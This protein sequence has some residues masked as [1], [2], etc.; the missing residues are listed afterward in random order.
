MIMDD[1]KEVL[2]KVKIE[3]YIAQHLSRS[4]KKLGTWLDMGKCPF[5]GGH[6]CFRIQP[7]QQFFNCFQCEA[8]GDVITFVRLYNKLNTNFDALKIVAKEIGYNLNNSKEFHKKS[9]NDAM[10]EKI[11]S[12]AAYYYHQNLFKDNK[13]L[14][15][16]KEKRCHTE[17]I[18]KKFIIGYTGNDPDGLSKY[19]LQQGFEHQQILMTGLAKQDNTTLKDFFC[20]HL[21]IYPW[22]YYSFVGH[23]SMK[24]PQKKL[25]Y[26]LPHKFKH[27]NLLFY[28]QADIFRDKIILVEGENDLLTVYR[29]IKNSEQLK[30]FGVIGIHGQI[31]KEQLNYLRGTRQEKEIYCCF[32]NDVESKTGEKYTHKV[33]NAICDIAE[34][35]VLSFEDKYKDIDEYLRGDDFPGM[36]LKALIDDSID[37]IE[38]KITRLPDC[39]KALKARKIIEPILEIIAKIKDDR[40]DTYIEL[41]TD[42]Y[43]CLKKQ[44][45]IKQLK[46]KGA[47]IGTNVI[48]HFEIYDSTSQVYV[49]ENSYY[50][51]IKDG[52]PMVSNFIFRLIN[53]Y[54]YEDLQMNSK[55]LKYECVMVNY[56]DIKSEPIVFDPE[57]R[58]NVNKFMAKAASLGEY[59]FW[60]SI[61]NLL[62]VWSFVEHHAEDIKTTFL[63]QKYGY[64]QSADLWLFNDCA[65]KDG[66]IY[67]KKKDV[68]FVNDKGYKSDGVV[69]YGMGK[70]E[71]NVG[72]ATD[73][74]INDTVKNYWQICDG[75]DEET[76]EQWSSFKGL[77]MFGLNAAFVY[78]EEI[79]KKYGFFPFLLVFSGDESTG[80]TE[81]MKILFSFWGFNRSEG[82]MYGPTTP[83]GLSQLFS[84]LCS[85]PIWLD[86]FRINTNPKHVSVMEIIRNSYNR[87][88]VSKG[89]VRNRV[90][91]PIN[92]GI[93]I[94]GQDTPNDSAT[95][96]RFIT[97]R[98][99]KV[100]DA[101]RKV[102]KWFKN[103][104]QKLPGIILRFIKEKSKQS[105][106]D[107]LDNIDAIEDI[108]F[109]KGIVDE[110]ARQNFAIAI[111]A[112]YLFNYKNSDNEFN[113][114]FIDWTAD[115]AR[116]GLQRS[117]KENLLNKFLEDVYHLMDRD[118]FKKFIRFQPFDKE[119]VIAFSEFL[120]EYEEYLAKRR[121]DLFKNFKKATLEED[122]AKYI[123]TRKN[124]H[125]KES[126]NTIRLRFGDDIRYYCYVIEI[127]KIPNIHLQDM[128]VDKYQDFMKH[129]KEDKIHSNIKNTG[130]TGDT[131]DDLF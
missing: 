88:P 26:Q 82:E 29:A 59:H 14:A 84:Q 45:I 106:Q 119:L 101:R 86:E 35:F 10:I 50:V 60:G 102:F 65:I 64:I 37:G 25:V 104:K 110:R 70:P 74:F 79:S 128:F 28:N 56:K 31:S 116:E 11:F 131:G 53:R 90:S 44:N 115:I 112:F 5:C 41:L 49:S 63:M 123:A 3:D 87:I 127:Y 121:D 18:L 95:L 68:I 117:A 114:K 6:D 118:P 71:L 4:S 22:K 89:G 52:K 81:N 19:L 54:S 94:S 2:S 38:W 42:K 32:D 15:W 23:F 48:Q 13:A 16:I 40:I 20:S 61:Q 66:Q 85:I 76:E 122:L 103:N 99:S 105:C 69:A 9:T 93:W 109:E 55:Y 126:R 111:G 67:E 100:N 27:S 124:I 46:S 39:D 30:N 51:Q 83:A 43:S 24:D 92:T 7:E 107:L 73:D 98:F 120:I 113:N 108:L 12:M 33:I 36:S 57:E 21:F 130:D 62:N 125:A 91:F 96:S 8:G 129:Y 47:K 78:Y 77:L 34:T 1:F 75:N 97:V 58:V 17:D 80:K 72:L